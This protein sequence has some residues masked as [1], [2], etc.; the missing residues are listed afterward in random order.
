MSQRKYDANSCIFVANI[1]ESPKIEEDLRATFVPFGPIERVRII[2]DKSGAFYA[3]IQYN[4]PQHAKNALSHSQNLYL[5]GRSLRCEPAQTNTTLFMIGRQT[6]QEDIRIIFSPFGPI[7]KIT[8]VRD[9]MTQLSKG[10]GFV[11]YSF[12]EDAIR[13]LTNVR[14]SKKSWVVEWSNTAHNARNS[15][16]KQSPTPPLSASPNVHSSLFWDYYKKEADCLDDIDSLSKSPPPLRRTTSLRI[17]PSL[18]QPHMLGTEPSS[19]PTCTNRVLTDRDTNCDGLFKLTGL[20]LSGE[21]DSSSTDSSINDVDT[22]VID[23]ESSLKFLPN[24][25]S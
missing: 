21:D 24:H 8:I 2:A 7:E 14:K 20:E 4:D 16:S 10:C 5:Y 1:A 6:S 3:F 19:A 22:P 15:P 18:S 11:K 25:F 17:Y 23:L 9:N 13:A 12:R